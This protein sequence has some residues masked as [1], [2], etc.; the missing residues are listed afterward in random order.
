MW[1]R[2]T[3]N[4]TGYVVIV[5]IIILI[6]ISIAKRKKVKQAIINLKDTAMSKIY[7]HLLDR[8]G[9]FKLDRSKPRG[10][11]NNNPGNLIKTSI[12]WRG[13]VEPAR[14]SDG[15]FEQFYEMKYGVRAMLKDLIN[16]IKKKG[17]NTVTLLISEFAPAHENNTQAYINYVAK[18]MGLG[19]R[20]PFIVNKKNM[21]NLVMAITKH[22]NGRQVISEQDFEDAWQLV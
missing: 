8:N 10:Q 7:S 2:F 20:T 5:L 18:K 16:D 14:N 4:R 21:K 11:R 9:K 17:K 13:K 1:I 6:G 22:E 19:V 3:P 15:H 12:N